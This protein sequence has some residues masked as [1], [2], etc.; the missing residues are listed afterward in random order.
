LLN[1][2]FG[3][4]PCSSEQYLSHCVRT[5]ASV[6]QLSIKGTA[7]LSLDCQ[8]KM[9]GTTNWSKPPV[10]GRL[11]WLHNDAL[12]VPGPLVVSGQHEQLLTELLSHQF[13]GRLYWEFVLVVA[14][15]SHPHH[16]EREE[17]I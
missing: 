1:A 12:Q 15:G 14:T 9:C 13:K 5:C 8:Y 10:K 7:P 3:Q 6:L 4:N 11:A 16:H 17:A 2:P